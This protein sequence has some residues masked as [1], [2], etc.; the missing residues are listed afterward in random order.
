M[1]R[2]LDSLSPSKRPGPEQ[3]AGG[4]TGRRR[5]TVWRPWAAV[6]GLCVL[7]TGC[8]PAFDISP[9]EV[10]QLRTQSVHAIDGSVQPVPKEWKAE[11]RP[12]EASG[13]L[14]VGHPA[15]RRVSAEDRVRFASPGEAGLVPLGTGLAASHGDTIAPAPGMYAV[16]AL[17]LR[18][19]EGDVV[20]I[21]L[22]SIDR[23]HVYEPGLSGGAIAG[24]VCGT[25]AG[26]GAIV[27]IIAG[28]VS[29]A[30]GIGNID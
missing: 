21:P 12:T 8:K 9:I 30:N 16:P 19:D 26:V 29:L 25:L 13:K 28:S 7:A 18:E 24:I 6:G 5:W 1:L 22:G 4:S 2:F 17:W 10:P 27:A 20:E 11:V 14:W 15:E 3:G 23:V